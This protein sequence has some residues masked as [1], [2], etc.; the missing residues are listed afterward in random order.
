ML[1]MRLPATRPDLTCVEEAGLQDFLSA[2]GVP[3][4]L[5]PVLTTDIDRTVWRFRH[6]AAAIA[7]GQSLAEHSIPGE[8]AG[9][10]CSL[11]N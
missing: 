8:P 10:G 5:H 1:G 3:A 2:I 6:R 11:L 7:R 9:T 4:W